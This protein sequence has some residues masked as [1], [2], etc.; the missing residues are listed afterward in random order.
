MIVMMLGLQ[1]GEDAEEKINKL[2]EKLKMEAK[3]I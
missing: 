1:N 3:V 2:I